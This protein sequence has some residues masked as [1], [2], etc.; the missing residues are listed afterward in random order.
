MMNFP[1]CVTYVASMIWWR[2]NIQHQ[3][4][5]HVRCNMTRRSNNINMGLSCHA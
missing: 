3:S 5:C 1:H 4:L 2:H